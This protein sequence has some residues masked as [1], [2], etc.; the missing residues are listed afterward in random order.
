MTDILPD[1]VLKPFKCLFMP[2][3]TCG[4]YAGQAL[5]ATPHKA[6]LTALH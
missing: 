1:I 4:K 5:K 6:R 3:K 2:E